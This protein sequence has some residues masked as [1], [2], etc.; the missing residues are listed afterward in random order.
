M[1][2]RK[3]EINL[4]KEEIKKLIDGDIY[5]FGSRLDDKK[6]GGDIDIFIVPKKDL[7]IKERV[8]LSNEIKINLEYELMIPI[9]VIISKNLNRPIEKEALKG[10]KIGQIIFSY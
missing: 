8:K 7:S 4:I 5:I 3:D 6:K 1:R 9:D 2:L 10:I